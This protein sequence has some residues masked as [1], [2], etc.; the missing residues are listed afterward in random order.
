[1]RRE[2]DAENPAVGRHVVIAA[3]VLLVMLALVDALVAAVPR[4]QR[5]GWH[6]P[7]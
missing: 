3:V 2:M 4:A 5:R 1:M 6:C 7:A